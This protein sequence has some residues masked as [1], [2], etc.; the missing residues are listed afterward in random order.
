MLASEG[1]ANVLSK[2]STEQGALHD[3]RGIMMVSPQLHTIRFRSLTARLETMSSLQAEMPRTTHGI[4]Y[5][6]GRNSQVRQ[7]TVWTILWC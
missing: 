5:Y 1:F 4:A 3:A 6:Q 7:R 2:V